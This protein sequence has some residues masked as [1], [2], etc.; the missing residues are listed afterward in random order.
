[1]KVGAGV[2]ERHIHDSFMLVLKIQCILNNVD[3]VSC[4]FRASKKVSFLM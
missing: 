3:S 4:R 1:M 2:F